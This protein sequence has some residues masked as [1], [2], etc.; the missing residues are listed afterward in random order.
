[1]RED[2]FTANVELTEG[3]FGDFAK[4]VGGLVKKTVANY[5]Y[6]T[7][8]RDKKYDPSEEYNFAETAPISVIKATDFKPYV[9]S[10][11]KYKAW[12]DRDNGVVKIEIDATAVDPKM[13]EL[14]HPDAQDKTLMQY[15]KGYDKSKKTITL[16]MPITDENM[17][18]R[19]HDEEEFGQNKKFNDLKNKNENTE[20]N[21]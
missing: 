1:M 15:M 9:N 6:Y 16:M 12:M 4:K 3:K 2:L 13:G 10:K 14:L 18:K 7:G 17:L 20:E 8:K 5:N 19:L 21:K 11:T